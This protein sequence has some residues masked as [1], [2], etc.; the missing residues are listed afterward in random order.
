MYRPGRCNEHSITHTYTFIQCRAH[1]CVRAQRNPIL[2]PT[3]AEEVEQPANVMEA[4]SAKRVQRTDSRGVRATLNVSRTAHL[5]L[6]L[7]IAVDTPLPIFS[8]SLLLVAHVFLFVL[9]LTI[10]TFPHCLLRIIIPLRVCVFCVEL[11]SG[12]SGTR[13]RLCLKSLYCVWTGTAIKIK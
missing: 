7:T 3:C 2:R 12:T 10:S 9:M 13:S 4:G 5:W 1:A 8:V 11:S 6:R